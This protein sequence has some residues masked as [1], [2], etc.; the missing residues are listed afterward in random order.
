MKKKNLFILMI[1]SVFLLVSQ[2]HASVIIDQWN[3][4][5]TGEFISSTKTDGS[6]AATPDSQILA[7]GEGDIPSQLGVNDDLAAGTGLHTIVGLGPV[8]LG[9]LGS[10]FI[11]TSV[12]MIH[13]NFPVR[14]ATLT[15]ATMEATVFLDP[16]VPDLPIADPLTFTFEIDFEET[17]NVLDGDGNPISPDSDDIFRLVAA[18]GTFPQFNFDYE[19]RKYVVSLFPGNGLEIIDGLYGFRTKENE[20]T[21][22]PF[23]FFIQTSAIPEPS[24][25]LLIGIGLLGLAGMARRKNKA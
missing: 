4:Q 16:I 7:W 5:I 2:A 20:I 21:V 15:E 6:S 12:T 8:D 22:L 23:G 18:P 14:G 11:G 25:S 13:A 24:T 1:A 19:G 3:Y 9:T 10:E 17:P